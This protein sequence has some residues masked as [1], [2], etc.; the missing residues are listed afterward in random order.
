MTASGGHQGRKCSDQ[1]WVHQYGRTHRQGRE[2][3]NEGQHADGPEPPG[4]PLLAL[5]RKCHDSHAIGPLDD[6][7]SLDGEEEV[8]VKEAWRRG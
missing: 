5:A 7:G 6:V 2:Q 4:S 1:R 3:P 8:E